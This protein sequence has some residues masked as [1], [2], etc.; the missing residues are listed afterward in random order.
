ML[1][2]LWI[3]SLGIKIA[4]IRNEENG[5]NFQV[6]PKDLLSSQ[7]PSLSLIPEAPSTGW[8]LGAWLGRVLLTQVAADIASGCFKLS[9]SHNHREAGIFITESDMDGPLF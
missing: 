9:F 8:K 3:I 2:H 6:G 4:N 5:T 1:K 7:I